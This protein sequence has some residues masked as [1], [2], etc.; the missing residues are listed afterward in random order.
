MAMVSDELMGQLLK[1]TNI[2]AE[3]ISEDSIKELKF[4]F[5]KRGEALKKRGKWEDADKS[6]VEYYFLK[7]FMTD[8]MYADFP[9]IIDDFLKHCS[10]KMQ[11]YTAAWWYGA[12]EFGLYTMDE[13][14]KHKIFRAIY[15]G[16][17]LG[18]DYCRKLIIYMYKT[19]FKKEYNQFK[20][21]SEISMYDVYDL[22]EREPD[23]QKSARILLMADFL[24]IKHD[25]TC[26]CLNSFILESKIKEIDNFENIINPE[27]LDETLYQ[28]CAIQANMWSD[29]E[30]QKHRKHPFREYCKTMA[31]SMHILREYGLTED[32]ILAHLD[33]NDTLDMIT[34]KIAQTLYTLGKAE[35]GKDYSFEEVQC[36]AAIRTIMEEMHRAMEDLQNEIDGLLG[37]DKYRE[38]TQKFN[39]NFY[40]E[41]KKKEGHKQSI[42][43]IKTDKEKTTEDT[44]KYIAENEGLKRK[45]NEQERMIHDLQKQCREQEKESGKI[46]Q[47]LLAWKDERT[48]LVALRNFVYQ[49]KI[50]D[51]SPVV[52]DDSIDSMKKAIIDKDVII[53]GGHINW[54]NKLRRIFPKWTFLLTEEFKTVDGKMLENKEKVYFFTDHMNHMAY[55]KFVAACR[56]RNIE[57]GYLAT[58]NTNQL[59]QRVYEDL[60]D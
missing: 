17:K 10:D 52:S 47:Q 30:R 54:H 42:E 53:I 46:N 7:S 56:E 28:A 22:S 12:D 16:A 11:Q 8:E 25:D 5:F 45:I 35:P 57:F 27:P 32:C 13:A 55:G 48:E 20:R 37:D 29:Q 21:Y 60:C 31:F 33:E 23:C 9:T 44:A 26:S 40:T 2:N 41:P 34:Q 49:M 19:Y 1:N 36:A 38:Q 24:N 4:L 3:D 50:E 15:N 39:P 6:G 14:V 43:E 59:I 18:D 51:G 58:I